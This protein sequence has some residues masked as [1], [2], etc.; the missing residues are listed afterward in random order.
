M[1][2]ILISLIATL[3]ICN[4]Y[5]TSQTKKD[6][7]KYGAWG[8]ITLRVVDEQDNIVTNALVNMA[9]INEYKGNQEFSERTDENGEVTFT[10]TVNYHSYYTIE[11]DGY[12]ETKNR[13]KFSY[14][15]K[16]CAERDKLTPWKIKWIPWNPTVTV[17]LKKIRNPIPMKVRKIEII[18]PSRDK[19]YPFDLD[20]G[21]WVEPHG[22]GKKAHIY[23]IMLI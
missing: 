1:K 18:L 21:D 15:G 22:T 17:V 20:I 3:T 10:G 4:V 13:H 7:R 16:E 6:A 2:K 11:E 14:A 8:K 12:Y 9:F 19:Y 23:I 5:A